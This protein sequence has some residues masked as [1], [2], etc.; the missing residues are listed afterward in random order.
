MFS[1][2]S[3]AAPAAPSAVEAQESRP[4]SSASSAEVASSKAV[5]TEKAMPRFG[6]APAEAAA[7]EIVRRLPGGEEEEDARL[8]IP[9]EDVPGMQD[10]EV[11]EPA[12][13]G[14]SPRR[15]PAVQPAPK[16]VVVRRRVVEHAGVGSGAVLYAGLGSTAHQDFDDGI[17]CVPLLFE[18]RET[19]QA[20]SILYQLKTSL[21][22]F[23][24]ADPEAPTT[25]AELVSNSYYQ[26]MT[27]VLKILCVIIQFFTSCMVSCSPDLV[28]LVSFNV[29]LLQ[30]VSCSPDLLLHACVR[31]RDRFVRRVDVKQT[32]ILSRIISAMSSAP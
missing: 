19:S 22:K 2:A 3:S 28:Q 15:S 10:R 24:Q 11:P 1:S 21:Q 26:C 31:C 25:L 7:V 12:G 17:E 30:L 8:D 32:K 13:D 20:L 9:T 4:A 18:H 16:A 29:I 23:I 27:A 5:E 6:A 14:S